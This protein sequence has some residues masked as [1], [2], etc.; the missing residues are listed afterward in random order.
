MYFD[1]G[2]DIKV[3][4]FGRIVQ[5]EGF[6]HKNWMSREYMLFYLAQGDVV[7]EVTGKAI[8]LKAGDVLLLPPKTSYAPLESSGCVYYF[9]YF[10]APQT[11]FSGSY[12]GISCSN[13]KSPSNF[14]FSYE[15]SERTVI[16]LD[17][18]IAHVEESDIEE[19]LVKCTELDIWQR[20]YE[21]MLLDN[22]LKEI[23][24]RLSIFKEEAVDIERYFGR[25]VLFVRRNYKKDIGLREVAEE[26]GISQS[27]A[28]KLFRKNTGMRCCD[29]INQVRLDAACIM[30]KNTQTHIG[31]IATMVGFNS[32]Y[33][34]ARRFK[35]VYGMTASDFRKS[36]GLQ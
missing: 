14:S 5:P 15:F 12:F 34:F 25:M 30:L 17:Q 19:V 11:E 8:K 18:Y 32:Q 24:I 16:E 36:S 26:V 20:P 4:N 22:Y 1:M 6:W 7:M 23:L 31:E 29:Y 21:K 35:E 9:F 27:Y 28:S 2:S 33:Y 3:T 13:C 10:T